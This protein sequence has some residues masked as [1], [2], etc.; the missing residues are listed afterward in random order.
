MLNGWFGMMMKDL[1]TVLKAYENVKEGGA[2]VVLHDLFF[3]L[4]LNSTVNLRDTTDRWIC[5]STFSQ[6]THSSRY[7]E[8][9][10]R[11]SD[12][13]RNSSAAQMSPHSVFPGKKKPFSSY[14]W[15]QISLRTQFFCGHCLFTNKQTNQV[16]PVAPLTRLTLQNVPKW[17]STR[18]Q[19][20]S[21]KVAWLTQLFRL[22]W[23]SRWA[24]YSD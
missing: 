3:Q 1:L 5:T 20:L 8:T 18:Q 17:G 9:F 10:Q 24:K 14:L 13:R 7:F 16:N 4:L 21:L 22:C 19:P 15:G 11:K 12:R 6:Q 2:V 23:F